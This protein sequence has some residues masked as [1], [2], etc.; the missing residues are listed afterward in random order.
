MGLRPERLGRTRSRR[1]LGPAARQPRGA[2]RARRRPQPRSARRLR[3]RCRPAARTASGSSCGTA[4][5]PTRSTEPT[6]ACWQRSARSAS[7]RRAT[8]SRASTSRAAARESLKHLEDEG[9]LRS[10]ARPARTSASSSSRIA[11]VTCSKPTAGSA[12]TGRRRAAPGLLR[13]PEEAARAGA[14]LPGL[15]RLPACRGAS[16]KPGGRV[17]RVVLDYELKRDYQRFLQERNRD[18][19]DSDGRPDRSAREIQAWAREHRLPYFDEHVHFPD[20]ADR[21][22]RPRGLCAARGHRG[23]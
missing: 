22:R 18:R 23:R 4:I 14:R 9:L 12:T 21:V 13:G 20:A 10:A 16:P 7:C 8:S 17:R 11:D 3:A 15:S 19:P 5:G 2:K 1:V 6:A